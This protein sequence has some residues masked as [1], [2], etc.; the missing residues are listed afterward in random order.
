MRS[1]VMD[2]SLS[3]RPPSFLLLANSSSM[4]PMRSLR[5]LMPISFFWPSESSIC[6]RVCAASSC[7]RIDL[8]S[9]SPS[10]PFSVDMPAVRACMVHWAFSIS[11]RTVASCSARA[12][13]LP[14][15]S[16]YFF[17]FFSVCFLMSSRAPLLFCRLSW[18]EERSASRF[19][20]LDSV[21]TISLESLECSSSNFFS[22]EERDLSRVAAR[23]RVS[24][25]ISFSR[26]SRAPTESPIC[27]RLSSISS[28][29]VFLLCRRFVTWTYSKAVQKRSNR[30]IS[31]L[32]A[33]QSM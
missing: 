32:L 12:S 5:L 17:S 8:P 19:L 23:S 31:L 15:S 13:N 10:G 20:S 25:W 1:W 30:S 7:S 11:F 6:R 9:P 29:C 18:I 3:R 27:L 21:E 26:L 22:S 2:F 4:F 24:L 16:L 28:I 14:F 33:I